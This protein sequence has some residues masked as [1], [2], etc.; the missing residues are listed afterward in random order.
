MGEITEKSMEESLLL[1]EKSEVKK[2]SVTW[3]ALTQEL[4][5]V[6]CI[7]G[8][9]VAVS[10]TQNLM[11]VI[12]LM[13]VGHLGELSLSSTAIS[14]SLA[15]VTGFSLLYRKLGI[16]THTAIFSLTLVCFPVSL[17]WIYMG[18][19][20]SLIGQDPLISY[21]A[22]KFIVWLIPTL[23]ASAALQPL[24]RFFQTQSL[25][26]PML[27]CACVSLCLH[28]PISWVLIFKSGLDNLGAAV[29]LGISNWLNVILL[30]LYMNYSSACEKTRVPV[31]M[32]LFHGI[33]E[34]FRF[35]IPSAIMICLTT[36]STL[37]AV[38]Y[39]LGAAVSTR[40]SNEL[41]AGNPQAARIA[42]FAG[43]SFGVTEACI[44]STTLF[45]G[46]HVFGYSFSNVKEVVDYVTAMAPLICLSITVDGVKGHIGANVN[47]GAYYLCGIPTAA[48]LG[49]W[50]QLRGRGLWIGI[51]TGAIVQV[52]LLSIITSCTN[53]EKQASR[54]RERLFA[55]PRN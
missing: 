53:W 11:Q 25:I 54:A 1:K 34:F 45:V 27:G 30:G 28:V 31:S 42:V 43:F 49:F 41:G 15:G 46:R 36:I 23:F 35:A 24:I 7:A 12:S 18:K 44:L 8:P 21:E 14:I 22:G 17:L 40:V 39:G 9:M 6:G 19:L 33:R 3:S 16:Q 2:E 51:Q 5:R 38:P 47:L 55:E 29:A 37:Y 4:K 13:M 32:E 48:L 10:L 26:M 50:M 52:V 20:L